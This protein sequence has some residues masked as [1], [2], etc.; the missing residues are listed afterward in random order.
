MIFVDTSVWVAALRS[1]PSPEAAE[2]GTLLSNDT[3]ALAAPVLF[4]ILTGA[5]RK[6]YPRLCRTLGALPLYY[7]EA[8]AWKLIDGWVERAVAAGQRFGVADLL[9]AAIAANHDSPLWSLDTDFR[10]MEKLG[11]ICTYQPEPSA[12]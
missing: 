5:S 1:G 8:A 9:I 10:R 7:P 11:F 6:D 2:L 4:E 12:A 3:V